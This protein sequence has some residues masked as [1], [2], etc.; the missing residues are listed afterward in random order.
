MKNVNNNGMIRNE[1]KIQNQDYYKK[2][3]EYDYILNMARQN[4]DISNLPLTK[5]QI[6]QN[7]YS[8]KRQK[9]E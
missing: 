7:I 9:Y 1:D 4:K 3:S 8:N 6:L 2:I 5:N